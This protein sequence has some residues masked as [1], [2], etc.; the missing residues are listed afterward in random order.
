M[1][2]LVDAQLPRRCCLWLAAAGHDA[3]HTFDLPDGNA[4]PD[5]DLVAYADREDR[6][7]V[8]KDDDFVRSFV[9][10]GRPRK[11][12][13]VSTGNMTNA[14]LERLICANLTRI[15]LALDDSQFVE[16]NRTA[17]TIRH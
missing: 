15:E 6:I 16:L 1:K 8:T 5:A 3:R 14:E 17:V 13:L 4:T 10:S 7:L 11:L 12:L 9:L 2:F